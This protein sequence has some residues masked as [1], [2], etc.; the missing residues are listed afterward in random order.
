M[1][2]FLFLMRVLLR[3]Q[4]L[5]VGVSWIVLALVLMAGVWL[6]PINVALQLLLS[7]LGYVVLLRFGVLALAVALVF[8]GG[9]LLAPVTPDFSQW[10]AWRAVLILLPFV[11][12]L[13]YGFRTALGRQPIFGG[14][15]LDE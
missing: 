8:D 3:K 15:A 10:Y 7:A 5:A 11:A 4:W 14:G 6:T 1:I 13:L 9:L 2:T 12:L